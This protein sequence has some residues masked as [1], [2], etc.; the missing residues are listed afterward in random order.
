M[1]KVK[2]HLDIFGSK[3]LLVFIF[4]ALSLGIVFAGNVIVQ[5]GNIYFDGNVGI[6]TTE[7]GAPLEVSDPTS[8]NG[9]RVVSG[10][11][12]S[13]LNL[14][15]TDTTAGNRNWRIANRF[16]NFGTLNFMYSSTLGGTPDTYA[17]SIANNGNVGIGTASPQSKLDVAG[18]PIYARYSGG[19]GGPAGIYDAASKNTGTFSI[20][21]NGPG[22]CTWA[23]L[24]DASIGA[25]SYLIF[26]DARK[27]T[28][29]DDIMSVEGLDFVKTVNPVHFRWKTDD[30]Q[31]LRSQGYIAQQVLAAG[32]PN[33]VSYAPDDRMEFESGEFDGVAIDS[34]E[35]FSLTVNYESAIPY[36]H[37]AIK[38]QQTMIEQMQKETCEKDN[39]YSWC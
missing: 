18:A 15:T 23:L 35:G 28:D 22:C 26:S 37:A 31:D 34:P 30:P 24:S 32:Y 2:R 20:N 5:N 25:L 38:E 16:S 11:G 7:P 19:A 4:V 10:A 12:S 21:S 36:L 9:I 13:A 17:M 3:L 27:K 8:N 6:G 14:Y 1:E 39:S 33:L 29:I